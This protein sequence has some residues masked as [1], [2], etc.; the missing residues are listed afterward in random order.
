MTMPF[1]DAMKRKGTMPEPGPH[2][3]AN[4]HEKAKARFMRDSLEGCSTELEIAVGAAF[5]KSVA[6]GKKI[7][8]EGTSCTVPRCSSIFLRD[9]PKQQP[10][11][12]ESS[13]MEK[14]EEKPGSSTEL[15]IAVGHAF[16]KAMAA[17]KP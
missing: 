9:D 2:A 12:S 13:S 10:R 6:S 17:K 4:A 8:P 3:L 14:N 15:E 7:A 16:A 1:G 5:N 11:D